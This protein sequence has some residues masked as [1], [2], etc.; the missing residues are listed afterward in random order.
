MT[1]IA[2]TLT[3]GN[4]ILLRVAHCQRQ[5][6]KRK[7]PNIKTLKKCKVQTPASTSKITK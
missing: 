3:V 5:S 7:N 2:E 1:A 4:N 6:K